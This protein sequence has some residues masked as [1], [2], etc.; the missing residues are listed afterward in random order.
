MN[1]DG[2][3]SVKYSLASYEARRK[4]VKLIMGAFNFNPLASY[5]ARP[6][7]AWKAFINHVISIHSPLTKRDLGW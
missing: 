1:I 5:E 4:L 7:D 3:L 6:Q 2:S